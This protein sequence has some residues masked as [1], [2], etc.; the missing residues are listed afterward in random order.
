M[1][2]AVG[3]VAECIVTTQRDFG[4]RTD[5]KQARLK[6]TIDRMGVDEFKQHVEE[7]SGVKFKKAKPYEFTMHSDRFGWVENADGTWNLTL[8]IENGRIAESRPAA[9]LSADDAVFHEFVGV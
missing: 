4:N 6:Y 5:R 3:A 2:I 8:F 9:S 7:R 1:G